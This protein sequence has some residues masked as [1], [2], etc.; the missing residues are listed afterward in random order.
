MYETFPIS[1]AVT[2]PFLQ[3]LDRIASHYKTNRS[4]LIRELVERE[5]ADFFAQDV[6]NDSPDTVD[7]EPEIEPLHPDA[8]RSNDRVRAR[9]MGRRR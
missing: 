1:I 9:V 2:R 4:A 8:A 7:S 5:Y 6:D 3:A